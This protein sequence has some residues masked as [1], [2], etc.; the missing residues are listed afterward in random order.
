MNSEQAKRIAS[1]I[2]TSFGGFLVGWAASRGY[3]W[4]DILNQLLSSEVVVG[5]LTTAIT[6]AWAWISG[7]L[8]NLVKVVNAQPEIKGVIT[9]PTPEGVKLANAI[10][11]ATVA[12]AGTEAAKAVAAPVT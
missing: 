11:E 5:L 3:Q 4:G 6:V 7:K 9:A 10:P 1:W 8:P 2:A 12:P